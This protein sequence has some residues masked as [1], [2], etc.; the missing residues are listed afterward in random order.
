MNER[1]IK[2]AVDYLGDDVI[3]K[4]SNRKNKKLMVLN[5][6]TDKFIHFGDSRYSDYTT[7]LD[8]KKKNSYLKRSGSIKGNWKKNKY[9][10]N[11]L[12]REILWQ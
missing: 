4:P 5:P 8:N 12:A 7:T 9:S 10:K 6:S 1:I 11:N 2:N 3:I